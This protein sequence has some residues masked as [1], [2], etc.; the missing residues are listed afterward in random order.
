[1]RSHTAQP[2]RRS[3]RESKVRFF[4]SEWSGWAG[5]GQNTCYLDWGEGGGVEQKAT[6]PLVNL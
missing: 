1:M 6:I 5:S 3:D 4:T 2:P